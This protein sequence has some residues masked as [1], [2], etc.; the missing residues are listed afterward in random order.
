MQPRNKLCLIYNIAPSYREAIFKAIDAEYDCD[1]YFGDFKTDIKQMDTTLLKHVSF[2]HVI[3]K[4]SRICWKTKL[5]KLLFSKQYQT[6]FML[7]ESHSITDWLFLL[8]ATLFLK[9]KKIYVWGHGWYGKESRLEAAMKLWEFKHVAGAFVYGNYARNL[10]IEQ[11]IPADKLFVIHNS[12]HYDQQVELR[13]TL[14]PTDIYTGH[15]RN[16]NPTLIF[17]GRLTKVK[18][19][20][21]LVESVAGL[22]AKGERYN[23][24]FVG[25][26]NERPFLEHLVR[27]RQ[28]EDC[29]WFYGTCYD[30][31]TNAELIYN[32][33]LCV[34]PG[35]VGLTAM[36]S[37]VFGTPVISHNTF[38]W[39]MP[40]FEAIRQNATG[41]FFEYMNLESLIKAISRWFAV[42]KDK[43]EVVRSACYHEIDTQWNPYY[44]I[45]QIREHLKF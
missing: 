2:Y 13:R 34:A 12:L 21:L 42:K 43:R 36:H 31:R 16:D 15:F 45:E 18:Q 19:L 5:L 33:D 22:R 28:I 10:M 44:Q 8:L 26:G 37:M 7:I 41:D 1:W 30:E 6:Y 24:V 35:N 3:G 25:D 4:P 39:Q 9:K 20:D 38:K 40:E 27:E 29:V 17:I 32:A 11:G 14:H 23:L